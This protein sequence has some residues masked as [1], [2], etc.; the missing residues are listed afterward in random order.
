MRGASKLILLF[1]AQ[2]AGTFDNVTLNGTVL[3]NNLHSNSTC[4]NIGSG[5]A[6]L[7]LPLLPAV[8]SSANFV[9]LFFFSTA[10]ASTLC[11]PVLAI[12]FLD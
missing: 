6:I 1:Q 11:P 5:Y 10:S 3:L 7:A 8:N 4:D 12:L 9:Y 2:L